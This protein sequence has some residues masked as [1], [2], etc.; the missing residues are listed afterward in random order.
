[1]TNRPPE[2][3]VDDHPSLA[4]KLCFSRLE[5]VDGPLELQLLARY[6]LA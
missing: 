6:E 2:W 5:M 1:M 3:L 4:Q